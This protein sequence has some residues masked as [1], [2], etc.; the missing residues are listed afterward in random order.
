MRVGSGKTARKGRGKSA[1][2]G[3]GVAAAP[4]TPSAP[5]S[6]AVPGA[7]SA[8]RV[9]TVPGTPSAPGAAAAP[10][11]PAALGFAGFL[12]V[13][14]FLLWGSAFSPID[15]VSLFPWG[16]IHLAYSMPNI[17]SLGL[18]LVALACLVLVSDVSRRAGTR[19]VRRSSVFG[20]ACII[21]AV[22]ILGVQVATGSAVP[23][24]LPV[25]AVLSG[26]GAAL[27]L[28]AWQGVFASDAA[29]ASG[30]VGRLRSVV[31][32]AFLCFPPVSIACVLLPRIV[33][34]AAML[35]LACTSCVL[36]WRSSGPRALRPE[37]GGGEAAKPAGP[38][39]R[40]SSETPPGP[41]SE[42]LPEP[43]SARFSAARIRASLRGWGTSFVCL[44]SFGFVA[45]VLRS[46]TL[47]AVDDRTNV[48]IGSLACVFAA[49]VILLAIWRVGGRGFSLA[50]FYQVG[51][52]LIAGLLVVF[53]LAAGD[54][55]VTL[56]GLAHFFLE[57][58]LML[59][60][61]QSVEEAGRRGQDPVAVYG[62]AIGCAY[63]LLGVGTAAGFV[64][65]D[66]DGGAISTL[67]LAV[68]V[69]LYALS[70]P[71]VLQ[72]RKRV[73]QPSESDGGDGSAEGSAGVAGGPRSGAPSD[74]D[75][76]MRRLYAERVRTVAG[77]YGLSPREE[78]VVN[79]ALSGLDSPAIAAELGLTDN[80][81]RTYKKNAYKKLGVH[82]KQEIV[83]LLNRATDGCAADEAVSPVE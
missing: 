65:R 62:L 36:L 11:L 21:A 81:V 5:A 3:A 25:A 60:I 44:G 67:A 27:G 57:F 14:D 50:Q 41:S 70:I 40:T 82:S 61:V 37:R 45:G 13:V 33:A 6:P 51:F 31:A 55:T 75:F 80:T 46:L 16:R 69:C 59:I 76:D 10:I 38:C 64:F 32:L 20:H 18:S 1:H 8:T 68:V 72:F 7:L 28:L 79:L 63:V 53:S 29:I 49:T 23:S 4:G 34:Y 24:L 54:F 22:V 12:A 42:T 26:V 35:L 43:A 2:G 30:G 78:E 15:G 47:Y 66:Y 19:L 9:A 52:P 17:F 74:S 83:A 71:L 77:L 56:A 48:T 73:G 58:S 39:S